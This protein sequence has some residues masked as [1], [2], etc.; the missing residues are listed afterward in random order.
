M[1]TGQGVCRVELGDSWRPDTEGDADRGPRRG[2]ADP[3]SSLRGPGPDSAVEE[4][5]VDVN[6]FVTTAQDAIT[7][8]RVYGEPVE[9][10]G[11]TVIPAARVAG[12]GGGGNGQEASGQQGEGGGFGIAASPAGAFVI[13]EGSVRWMPAVDPARIVATAALALVA[14]VL[15]GGWATSRSIRAGRAVLSSPSTGRSRR[16]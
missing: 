11:V 9:R 14:V 3:V 16:G 12:G 15:A 2:R 4:G 7:V 13:R 10:D 6:Q 1:T 5:L 8:R